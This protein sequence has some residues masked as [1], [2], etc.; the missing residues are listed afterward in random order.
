MIE[1]DS[2]IISSPIFNGIL[3]PMTFSGSKWPVSGY[4]MEL[5]MP[6]GINY[7]TRVVARVY[8]TTMMC[9]REFAL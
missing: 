9:M 4:L 7:H 3:N 5:I 6:Y 8:Y 1:G 2:F